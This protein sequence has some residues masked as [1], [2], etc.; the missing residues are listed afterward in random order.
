[1]NP[2]RKSE[3]VTR[4][5]NSMEISYVDQDRRHNEIQDA[6][7]GVPDGIKDIGPR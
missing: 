7:S 6:N 5:M 2:S 4:T 1:M 3:M